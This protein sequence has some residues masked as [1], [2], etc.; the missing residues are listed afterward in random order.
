M[1]ANYLGITGDANSGKITEEMEIAKARV[2]EAAG[3]DTLMELSTGGDF[4][5]IRR[6]VIEATSLSLQLRKRASISGIH[7][8]HKKAWCR[9]GHD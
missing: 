7:R 6:R 4:H 5:E 1:P 9:G 2:A 3:A 8:G